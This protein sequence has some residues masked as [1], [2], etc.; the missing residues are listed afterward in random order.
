MNNEE[1]VLKNLEPKKVFYYFEEISRIPRGSGNI[2]GISDYLAGFARDH[3]LSYVQDEMYNVIIRKPATPGYENAPA[4]I[5]QGHMDM[6]CEKRPDVEHDFTKDPLKLII[7]DDCV[8]ADGTTLGGDD[9]IAVAYALAILDDDSLQHPALEALIT[10]DEEIGLLGAAGLDGSLLSGKRL[11]NLD[12]EEEGVLW[13]SCAGGAHAFSNIPVRRV[14]AEGTLIRLQVSGLNG[15][16]SGAEI[17]K[18]RANANLVMARYLHS[19]SDNQDFGILSFEGGTKDNAICRESAA[20]ILVPAGTEQAF[21]DFAQLL[22]RELR[23]EYVNTD[24]GVTIT[25]VC[26]GGQKAM[27]LDTTSQEKVL[28]FLTML[29]NGVAKMSGAI[30]DLV[31]TSSNLGILK[32]EEDHLTACTSVRSSIGTAKDCLLDKVRYLTEFLGGDLTVGGQYPAWEYAKE[33]HLRDVMLSVW[34]N[35]TGEELPVKAIHAGLECGLFC[36]KIKGL[37]CVSLGPRIVDI[38]TSEEHLYIS[39]TAT[40]Y[41]YLV[42]VL[43]QLKS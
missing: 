6:V 27:V 2:K 25:A 43:K 36:E 41:N 39:S 34:K 11:I 20:R 24:E 29:P 37:D 5:L 9:G 4:V 10:V 40:I 26:E 1:Y 13:V 42:E 7:R 19:M 17:D 38:H 35:M 23:T 15:G 12:S 22:T 21:I 3:G 30:K 8:Y 14:E 31:E 33:S 32:L 16:H 18:I 28:F